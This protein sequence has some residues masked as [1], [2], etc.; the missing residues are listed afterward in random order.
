MLDAYNT[1]SKRCRVA[2]GSASLRPSRTHS[3]GRLFSRR[4]V[5]KL[6][7]ENAKTLELGMMDGEE[8]KSMTDSAQGHWSK[9][10]TAVDHV[11]ERRY[12]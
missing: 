2:D 8:E 4:I 7:L 9:A 5:Q 12:F 10:T 6:H 3:D 11:H 1:S